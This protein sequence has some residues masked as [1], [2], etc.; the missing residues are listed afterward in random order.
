VVS[1]VIQLMQEERFG[2]VLVVDEQRKLVGIITERDLLTKVLGKSVNIA[3]IVVDDIM[4]TSPESLHVDDPI[5]FALNL[6]HF[7]G[8]RHIPLLVSDDD[9]RSGA[10]VGMVSIKDI[11]NHVANYLE[12]NLNAARPSGPTEASGKGGEHG[13][14]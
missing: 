7:G 10:P 4:S 12:A 2:C 14:S 1:E 8:F 3:D 11:V 6:M 13:L 5:A 9:A